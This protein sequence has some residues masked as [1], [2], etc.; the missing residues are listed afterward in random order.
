MNSLLRLSKG[1]RI[2]DLS[3]IT[4]E[5]LPLCLEG[6]RSLFD[7]KVKDETGRW[8][9]IEMQRKMEEDYLNRTQLYGCYTYVSQIKKGMKHKDLLPVVII[10]IIGTKALPDELPYVS[11]H[12][13]KESN[14]HKQYLFSLTYVFIELGKFK[15]MILKMMPMNGYIY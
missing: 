10:S 5:Q 6:K 4:T 3:Y 13:I 2:I 12:H 7:L 11:Y 15:K 14:T 8:Y 1:D 9:M